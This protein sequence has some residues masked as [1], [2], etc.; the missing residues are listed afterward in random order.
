[1][2]ETASRTQYSTLGVSSDT[3]AYTP[4][5]APD[6]EL[7]ALVVDAKRWVGE[8]EQLN[9]TSGQRGSSWMLPIPDGAYLGIPVWSSPGEWLRQLRYVVTHTETG[10]TAVKR[11]RIGVESLVAVGTAHARFADT[12][13][14]RDMTAAVEKIERVAG[15][16]ESVVHR[17]R[18]VLRDLGMGHEIVRG[19]HL[20]GHEFMAAELHH[21]GHQHR[22]ASVWALSSPR[23]VVEATPQAEI[24]GRTPSRSAHRAQTYRQRRQRQQAAAA[25]AQASN[26]QV[27]GRDT[28]SSGSSVLEKFSRKRE[29]TK[30]ART[31]AGA[32]TANTNQPLH[33]QR[34]AAELAHLA[35]ALTPD[36]HIGQLVDVLV[37]TGIDTT[38]WTGRDIADALTRDTQDRGWTWPDAKSWNTGGYTVQNPVRYA[39]MRLSRIDFTGPSPSQQRARID[40]QRRVEQAARANEA[41]TARSRAASSEHRAAMRANWRTLAATHASHQGVHE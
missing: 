29:L 31:H 39:H 21:G 8:L 23:W 25:K 18:R 26:P 2:P 1:M 35:P 10:R 9:H 13:T 38:R 37:S 14:G 16:S 4:D 11:H 17:A 36:K 30:R 34:A 33:T 32:I 22:A 20:R 12:E 3:S 24:P 7:A 27:T 5:T 15:V 28:L 40:V 19:R 41:A 6:S